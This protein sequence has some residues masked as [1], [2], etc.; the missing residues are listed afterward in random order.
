MTTQHHKLII[1]GSGPAGWTAAIYAARANLKPTMITGLVPGGQLSLTT[2]VDNWPGGKEGLQGPDLMESMKHHAERFNTN[3]IFDE[4]TSADLSKRPFTLTGENTYTCD[5][6]II[7]T[8]ASAKYL[9]LPS[10]EAY[11]GKGVSACAT[12]DGFFYRNQRVV[13]VGGGNTAVEETIYLANLVSHV[14]LIHRRDK[15][16]AEKIMVDHLLQKQATT[17]KI[18]IA[19]NSAI[20]EIMGDDQGVTGVRIKDVNTGTTTLLDVTGV[21]IAIGHNPNTA[22][23]K[24]QLDMEN[25]YIKTQGGAKQNATATRIPGVFAAG[26][27][28]DPTYRQAITA[29]GS[30]CMAALDADKYLD[31]LK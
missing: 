8:G 19:W 20:D 24:D 3:V 14:T 26:D 9:G 28:A 12:C 10:E 29:A 22:I 1:L 5:A 6:L 2:D 4:I 30:G 13:V 15:L 17:G 16:R 25:G 11:K 21:F 31:S 7:A 23:F 27:V 18:E